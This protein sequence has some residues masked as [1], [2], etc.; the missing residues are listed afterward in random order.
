MCTLAVFR[1]SS[2][3][4][5][6]IVVANR[7]EFYGRPARAPHAW[8]DH[9]EIFAG[10]DEEAGGTWLGCRTAGRP[11]V[12]GLLNR[13]REGATAPEAAVGERS[14]GL[15]CRDALA[16]ADADSALAALTDDEVDRYAGFNL[17]VADPDRAVVVDNGRGRRLTE[18]GDGLSVLTNL[19][20]NDPRCPRLAT[21][22]RAFAALEGAVATAT[23]AASLVPRFAQVLGDHGASLDVGDSSPFDRV[24]VHTDT[25]GTRSSSMLFV[26]ADGSTGVWHADGPPCSAP[27]RRLR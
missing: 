25:Y 26:A 11:R 5:P 7:D 12:V 4:Y 18:L 19:D 15:L 16:A 2:A 23:D 8:T 10:R 9:P 21:A 17:L 14:R 6:L 22:N 1:G 13:R 20:V 27:Y 3:A 24:C